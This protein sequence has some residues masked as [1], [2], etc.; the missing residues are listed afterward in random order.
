MKRD[1]A[2]FFKKIWQRHSL[3]FLRENFNP[4]HMGAPPRCPDWTFPSE[5][6]K[7][8][9]SARNPDFSFLLKRFP[10]SSMTCGAP[11]CR[12]Q[13]IRKSSICFYS[14]SILRFFQNRL[15]AKNIF[16]PFY[17]RSGKILC[18]S[19]VRQLRGGPG[20]LNSLTR[21]LPGGGLP[22]TGAAAPVG[23]AVPLPR[24]RVPVRGR[25]WEPPATFR[26]AKGGGRRL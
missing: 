24:G 20:G 19:M 26:Q 13:E 2:T 1:G 12:G 10:G 16:V 8:R 25:P 3:L 4:R 22:L 5:K 23:G 6:L 15:F 14:C 17:Y 9:A 11:F 7:V 18:K 21:C